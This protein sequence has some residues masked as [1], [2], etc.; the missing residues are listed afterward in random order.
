MTVIIHHH[1]SHNYIITNIFT[2]TV[3]YFQHDII[4]SIIVPT[5][6]TITLLLLNHISHYHYCS[7]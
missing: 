3:H 4:T 2:I 6:I 7:V 1:H 5:I